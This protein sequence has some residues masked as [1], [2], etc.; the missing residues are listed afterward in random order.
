[1]H[2]VSTSTP[3]RA[4]RTSR[5]I[6]VVVAVAVAVVVS[7]ASGGVSGA[8]EG[9]ARSRTARVL[10]AQQC[11]NTAAAPSISVDRTT[12]GVDETAVVNVRGTGYLLPPHVC[13]TDV[14]GGVYLFF[15]WVRPGGTWGPSFRSSTSTDGLFGTTFS[16]PGVGGG[17]ETRDDGTGSV[18]LV[19]FTAGGESGTSTPFH[20]DGAGNWAAD[21]VVRG[22]TYSFTDVRTGQSRTVDCRV[23]QCGVFTIGAHG[24]ASRT[25][26]RFVPIDF[27]DP[28]GRTIAPSAPDSAGAGGAVTSA[29]NVP[30][31]PAAGAAGQPGRGGRSGTAP[32]AAGGPAAPD[33][34]AA[35]GA[36]Q[37][38]EAPTTTENAPDASVAGAVAEADA[39]DAAERAASVKDFGS[40]GGGGALLPVVAIAAVV[41]VALAAT[42][43]VRRRR[44][45]QEI[46]P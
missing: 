28:T 13:G 26:E 24:K 32:G 42:V 29:G 16:Y 35:G 2:L 37:V 20:M 9:A 22:A 46:S 1:M 30:G 12:I 34:G 6:V 18:R 15:G 10:P 41:L 3:R 19:S 4:P 45:H 44:T 33:A 38:G 36:T 5:G 43:A 40:K 17:D 11:G 31:G 25:N 7:G 8:A 14:F 39:T 21:L 23:V 27:V